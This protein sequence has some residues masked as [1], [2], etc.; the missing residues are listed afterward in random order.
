MIFSMCKIPPD[1]PLSKGDRFE[2]NLIIT[3]S[4]C[5]ATNGAVRRWGEKR[6]G[7]L[8]P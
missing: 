6:K 3:V 8:I 5:K 7:T 4:S 1:L 2:K